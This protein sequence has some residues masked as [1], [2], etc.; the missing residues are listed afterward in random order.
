MCDKC[1]KCFLFIFYILILLVGSFF[2]IVSTMCIPFSFP[3]NSIFK[4]DK[5]LFNN[6]YTPIYYYDELEEI[7]SNYSN[8]IYYQRKYD[9]NFSYNY[10]VIPLFALLS[11]ILGANFICCDYNKFWFIFIGIVTI[12][13]QVIPFINKKNN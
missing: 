6:Y 8:N 7:Y 12:I 9:L 13:S 4:D 10:G 5:I 11:L 3:D 1:G 2:V